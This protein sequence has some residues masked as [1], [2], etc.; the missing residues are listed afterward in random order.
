MRYQNQG[1]DA[2]IPEPLEELFQ[3]AY[4]LVGRPY[5]RCEQMLRDRGDEALTF[6]RQKQDEAEDPFE[7]FMAATIADWI[8][9]KGEEFRPAMAQLDELE[10]QVKRTPAGA[11]RADIVEGVLTQFAEDRLVNFIALRLVKETYWPL[12][13]SLGAILYLEQHRATSAL[14]AL[15]RH[16]MTTR[17]PDERSLALEA[18]AAIKAE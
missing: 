11:P 13:K 10:I 8:E 1:N 14:P 6:L 5:L 12:W 18:I 2:H 16:A 4:S 3:Q 9:G 17:D 15:E 7:Q